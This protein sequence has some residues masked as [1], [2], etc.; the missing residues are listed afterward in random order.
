MGATWGRFRHV[1][2][3]GL[4]NVCRVRK[5]PQVAPT[6]STFF[7][8]HTFS[9]PKRVTGR[10]RPQVAPSDLGTFL[11]GNIRLG[12]PKRMYRDGK[13]PQVAGSYLGTFPYTVHTFSYP[14][15][16]TGRKRP[17]VAPTTSTFL[18]DIL[19]VTLN[20]LPDGNVPKS[21]PLLQL[22]SRYT[23]LG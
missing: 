7:T 3:L 21:L 16:V 18:H 11:H 6:T 14:K 1:T 10:K 22:F 15:R 4:L 2:R 9:Y 19:L 23:R 12:Y 20:V 5:R 13:V 17:Q 8:R